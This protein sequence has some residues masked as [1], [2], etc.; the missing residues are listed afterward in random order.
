LDVKDIEERLKKYLKYMYDY[1][2][3]GVAIVPRQALVMTDVEGRTYSMSGFHSSRGDMIF[4]GDRNI[5]KSLLHEYAHA[6][7]DIYK[8][9]D[10]IKSMINLVKRKLHKMLED[11]GFN[12]ANLSLIEVD[13]DA[14]KQSITLLSKYFDS[15][16]SEIVDSYIKKSDQKLAR[17]IRGLEKLIDNYGGDEAIDA[18]KKMVAEFLKDDGVTSYSRS[19]FDR[20]VKSEEDKSIIA[21]EAFASFADILEELINM[22][23]DEE[24]SKV[25]AKYGGNI[26]KF[27]NPE[28]YELV[29]RRSKL[30]VF[31]E[32][33]PSIEKQLK[34]VSRFIMKGKVFKE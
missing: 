4:V 26:Y 28:I 20:G 11:A 12:S 19:Y 8:R 2:F 7:F 13:D 1:A 15:M 31:R 5:E 34:V 30:H 32:L 27:F 24:L 18:Y 3:A 14:A 25:L 16:G 17:I 10:K 6:V 22:S 23:E 9:L 29:R 33:S 21:T